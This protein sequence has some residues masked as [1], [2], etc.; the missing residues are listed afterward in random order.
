MQYGTTVFYGLLGE[1][2]TPG[3][4]VGLNIIFN[5]FAGFNIKYKCLFYED[6]HLSNGI[7]IG[8]TF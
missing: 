1:S 7:G 3:A 8:L 6:N 5:E 2:L 4:E